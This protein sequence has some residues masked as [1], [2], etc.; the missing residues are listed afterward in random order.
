MISDF[1][2]YCR[3]TPR[4]KFL[5]QIP[6]APKTGHMSRW[7]TLTNTK[8]PHLPNISS[9]GDIPGIL[10]IRDKTE[11]PFKNVQPC[12]HIMDSFNRL[13][14]TRT[15]IAFQDKKQWLLSSLLW[16]KCFSLPDKNQLSKLLSLPGIRQTI[17]Y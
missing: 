10:I 2:P 5:S 12:Q 16:Q 17:Y 11:R 4:K 6:V 7:Y 3:V 15:K 1:S 14:R 13:T 8:R 9:L